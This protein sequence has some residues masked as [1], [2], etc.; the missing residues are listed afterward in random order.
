[1]LADRI[2]VI[3]PMKDVTLSVDA[4]RPGCCVFARD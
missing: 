2:L 1:V 4:V 3:A